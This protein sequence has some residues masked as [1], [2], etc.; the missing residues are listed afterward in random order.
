[1][2]ST[3]ALGGV[4]EPDDVA[5]VASVFRRIAVEPWFTAT[6][7][8]RDKFAR[9]IL[10]MYRQGTVLSEP[11]ERLC[12]ATAM[13]HFSNKERAIAGRGF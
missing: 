12:R 5:I 11:L 13:A 2:S 10:R 1:M 7:E 4:Y 6:D 8:E 9:Y 3:T